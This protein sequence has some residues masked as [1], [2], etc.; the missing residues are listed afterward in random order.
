[1]L[2]EKH[3]PRRNPL[4]AEERAILNCVYGCFS[5][6]RE[7]QAGKYDGR[8]VIAQLQ[9]ISRIKSRKE[10]HYRD[11]KLFFSLVSES[12]ETREIIIWYA[13]LCVW[14]LYT[15]EGEYAMPREFA[16][17]RTD[18]IHTRLVNPE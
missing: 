11:V 18:E 9:D 13:N 14:V 10:S 17:L 15:R 8:E 12:F 2:K 6:E 7:V 3:F 1:M 5:R 4:R 16:I